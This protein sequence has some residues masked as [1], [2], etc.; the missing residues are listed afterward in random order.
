MRTRSGL[1]HMS[2]KGV[3]RLGGGWILRKRIPRKLADVVGRKEFTKALTAKTRAAAEKEAEPIWNRQI[4]H[5]EKKRYFASWEQDGTLTMLGRIKRARS[6]GF[7]Y[8]PIGEVEKLPLPKLLERLRAAHPN[9]EPDMEI[10]AAVLGSRSDFLLSEIMQLYEWR[11]RYRWKGMDKYQLKRVLGPKAKAVR[12]FIDFAG[13][14]NFS[15][16]DS[17][18]L[19]DFSDSLRDKADAGLVQYS[20]VSVEASHLKCVLDEVLNASIVST[21]FD[22]GNLKLRRGEQIRRPSFTTSWIR[23]EILDPTTLGKL[24]PEVRALLCALVNTGMRVSEATGLSEGSIKLEG[25]IPHLVLTQAYRRLKTVNAVR[26]IPLVGVSLAAIQ[27]FPNG[28]QKLDRGAYTSNLLNK[29]LMVNELKQSPRHSLHS[30]RH[31]FCDRLVEA[32][33][34]TEAIAA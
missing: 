1:L 25:E 21:H 16:V 18:L 33:A 3:Y 13:D 26:K 7:A 11:N 2:F 8:L 4:Q 19:N 6:L 17:Q 9:E 22:T 15:N 5:W 20:T 23:D 31:S 27:G 29:Y 14:I 10:A 34:T 28:F 24:A 12:N 30:L 32:G